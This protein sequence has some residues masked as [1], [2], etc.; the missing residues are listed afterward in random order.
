MRMPTAKF[1]LGTTVFLRV[2]PEDAGMVTGYTIR[3]GP[4]LTYLIT[5]GDGE[6]RTHW[7]MELTSERDYTVT[8]GGGDA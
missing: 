3:F 1:E 8:G 6:E 5:W 4:T 7:E 2:A